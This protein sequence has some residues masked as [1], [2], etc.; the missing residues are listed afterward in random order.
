MEEDT[1]EQK[2]IDYNEGIKLAIKER[3]RSRQTNDSLPDNNAENTLNVKVDSN[4]QSTGKIF[5][6]I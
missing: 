3:S 6:R 2:V 1:Q 4:I 5:S